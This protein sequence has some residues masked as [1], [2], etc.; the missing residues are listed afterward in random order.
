MLRQCDRLFLFLLLL[1]WGVAAHAITSLNEDEFDLSERAWLSS[2]QELVIGMP[3]MGD[4]PYS[5]KDA[6]QRFTGPVP[7]IA[8]QIARTLG[9]TLRYKVY[10]SYVDAL[11]GLDHGAIDILVN[12]QP[13]EQ[14]RSN[15]VSLPFLLSMPRGVLLNNGKTKL[16]RQ[17]AH[18]LH[19][20]CVTGVNACSELKK[21]GF[22]RVT[23]AESRSEAAFM[24]KKRMAD[25]YLADMPSLV[26]VR[27]QHPKAGFTIATPEWVSG[28]SL[29]INM[30]QSAPAL[31]SLVSKAFNEIPVE[32]RRHM[33]AATTTSQHAD[34]GAVKSVQF[35]PEEQE[36]LNQ[37]PE[38]TYGVSPDWTSMSEFNYRGRLV[39]Y[40][41]DLMALMQQVSGLKFS[42][43]RTNSWGETQ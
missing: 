27:D 26:M 17:D 22:P 16:S 40:V 23:E 1:L 5:Y 2:H 30:N 6:D 10:P 25:A 15:I 12:D 7:D 36:W 11:T 31:V 43:V 37:H 3:M 8:Q 24:L 38:L 13:S 9:L 28:T 14:W 39:G 34:S 33:L 18:G 41:A 19:W 42:L 35:T 32:D 4:P 29:S 21:L 20:I